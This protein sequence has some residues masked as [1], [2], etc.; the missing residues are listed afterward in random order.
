MVLEAQRAHVGPC[1]DE[2][3]LR[4]TSVGCWPPYHFPTSRAPSPQALCQRHGLRVG[5]FFVP[6]VRFLIMIFYPFAKPIAAGL[7]RALGQEIGTLYSK[8]EVRARRDAPAAHLVGVVSGRAGAGRSACRTVSGRAGAGR[9][10]C[11]TVW[12]ARGGP[13]AAQGARNA[14]QPDPPPAQFAMLLQQ[15]VSSNLLNP[16][17]AAIMSGALTFKDKVR[18]G[19]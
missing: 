19:W 15:H 2:G 4:L 14:S 11:R 3:G 6:V 5:S 1:G 8:E 16:T 12:P 10:A 17:E 9:S 13:R 7:D 18:R